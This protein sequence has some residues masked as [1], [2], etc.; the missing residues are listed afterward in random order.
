VLLDWVESLKPQNQTNNFTRGFRASFELIT[1]TRAATNITNPTAIV[2]FL[3]DGDNEDEDPYPSFVQTKEGELAPEP[4]NIFIYLLGNDTDQLDQEYLSNISTTYGGDFGV[5]SDF[6]D[7]STVRVLM[8]RYYRSPNFFRY[9]TNEPAAP[10]ITVPYNDSDGLGIISTL[11]VPVFNNESG[12]MIGVAGV[13]FVLADLF[14]NLPELGAASYI[15]VIDSDNH[16]LLHPLMPANT[17]QFLDIELLESNQSEV[18]NAIN[19]QPFGSK[20]GVTTPRARPRGDV[21]AG[22]YFKRVSATYYWQTLN[23]TSAN[24]YKICLV[25]VATD[26]SFP[27]YDLNAT[28]RFDSNV[29]PTK[30]NYDR[31]DLLNL[32]QNRCTFEGLETI[33]TTSVYMVPASS[34]L[35]PTNYLRSDDNDMELLSGVFMDTASSPWVP[36]VKRDVQLSQ[37]LEQLWRRT[38]QLNSS[39][40]ADECNIPELAKQAMARYWGSPYSFRVFGAHR[41]P[42]NYDPS[43]RPWYFAALANAPGFGLVTYADAVTKELVMSLSQVIYFGNSTVVAGVLGVD[44]VFKQFGSFLEES[45]PLCKKTKCMVIDAS[46]FLMWHP[47]FCHETPDEM[48]IGYYEPAIANDLLKQEF[49]N[50]SRCVD[51]TEGVFRYSYYANKFNVSRISSLGYSIASIPNTTL[52]LIV[53]DGKRND[54]CDCGPKASQACNPTRCLDQDG[55][56]GLSILKYQCFCPCV[57]AAPLAACL[58]RKP[59][60]DDPV[61]P[62]PTPVLVSIPPTPVLSVPCPSPPA[63][64]CPA[65]QRDVG[66]LVGEIIGPIAAF[67]L[68]VAFVSLCVRP[69]RGRPAAGNPPPCT[70]DDFPRIDNTCE[71]PRSSPKN[72]ICT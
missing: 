28:P 54:A 29:D 62:A 14:V 50:L 56:P 71:I 57:C 72:V 52:Y 6:T 33:P 2:A 65:P 60:T 46:G 61:C 31:L 10:I 49:L 41:M 42:Q 32:P 39:C 4:A 64:T 11:A 27:V 44:F 25:L 8:G 66:K 53:V 35:N 37:R 1:T 51:Y 20:E 34:W 16:T 18:L 9:K 67:V 24:T 45:V 63:V 40:L 30:Q 3:T 70:E 58:P 12:N 15:F 13:D 43:L 19:Q 17:T 59:L 22:I 23:V 36:N 5:V 48:W 38:L 7:Q 69:K 26:L 21:N 68:F 55:P 47:T